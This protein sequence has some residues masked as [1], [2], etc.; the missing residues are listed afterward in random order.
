MPWPKILHCIPLPPPISLPHAQHSVATEHAQYS[1]VFSAT[2]RAPL[3]PSSSAWDVPFRVRKDRLPLSRYEGYVCIR[4]W[5]HLAGVVWPKR[6]SKTPL[7][8]PNQASPQTHQLT[9][10]QT[11][12]AGCFPHGASQTSHWF[13]SIDFSPSLPPR[14]GSFTNVDLGS[15]VTSGRNRL[16]AGLLTPT[17]PALKGKIAE[18]WSLT[19]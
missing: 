14:H 5:P 4:G 6:C 1:S 18:A 11:R 10:F 3:K 19:G 8:L 17:T 15:N 9:K 16:Q 12:R 13:S 7:H 2:H